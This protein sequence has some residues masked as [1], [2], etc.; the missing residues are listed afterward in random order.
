MSVLPMWAGK[1]FLLPVAVSSMVVAASYGALTWLLLAILGKCPLRWLS[2]SPWV[3]LIAFTHAYWVEFLQ[4]WWDVSAGM[5]SLWHLL[6]AAVGALAGIR[7]RLRYTYRKCNCSLS[8]SFDTRQV[9][10]EMS[11][12]SHHPAVA[13]LVTHHPALP[14]IIAESF[15]WKPMTIR[16]SDGWQLNLICTGRSLVTLPHFSYGAFFSDGSASA[17][18]I[19]QQYLHKLHFVKGFNGL[20]YRRIA[21]D[22]Q[23]NG[24]KVVSFLEL[25]SR[26]ENKSSGFSSNIRRKISKARRSGIEVKAGGAELLR[27]FYP[28]YAR[29]MHHLGSG[30][31]PLRFFRKLL[32]GYTGRDAGAFVFILYHKGKPQ[33]AAFNLFYR[34]FYENEWFATTPAVQK[35]YGSYALHAAM[36]DHATGLGADIY[37]FGQS[38]AGSGVHLFKKR[39]NTTDIPLQWIN[40]PHQSR[41]LRKQG[42]LRTIWKRMPYGV[43]KYVGRWVAKWVY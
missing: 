23:D 34:G 38:S 14:S 5:P 18:E 28:I 21:K 31:L 25:N 37:S 36:I 35:L 11:A 29:H 24:F 7:L 1:V 10:T 15:G 4:T 42:W 12:V 13:A 30:A 6:S 9:S 19:M 41:N 32:A 27:E 26:R 39:W 20:E 17:E 8:E 40:F 2:L 22:G 3:F 33:G 16:H 43:A